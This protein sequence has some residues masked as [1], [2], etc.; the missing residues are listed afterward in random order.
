MTF[1][2]NLKRCLKTCLSYLFNARGPHFKLCW[3]CFYSFVKDTI[4]SLIYYKTWCPYCL[5]VYYLKEKPLVTYH[6]DSQCVVAYYIYGTKSSS[7]EHLS[8]E[9]R[10]EIEKTVGVPIKAKDIKRPKECIFSLKSFNF[11]N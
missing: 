8:E 11:N 4:Y 7:L 2:T 6:C 3:L 1:Y 5:M 9:E 10:L